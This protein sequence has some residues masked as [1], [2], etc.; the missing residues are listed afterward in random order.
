M[1]NKWPKILKV[2]NELFKQEAN[3]KISSPFP[4][5]NFQDEDQD[6]IFEN[7][8]IFQEINKQIALLKLHKIKMDE[9]RE[10]NQ[11]FNIKYLLSRIKN[12]LKEQAQ[13][14]LKRKFLIFDNEF[15]KEN[16]QFIF[17]SLMFCIYIFRT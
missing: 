9:E 16:L 10:D 12:F 11:D 1:N 14:V 15:W 3:P 6:S 8:S 13:R 2:L 7:L 5:V 4:N 17:G